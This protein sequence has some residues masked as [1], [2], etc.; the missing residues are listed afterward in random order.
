MNGQ[1]VQEGCCKHVKC[2]KCLISNQ[3]GC[4]Q[5]LE[6]KVV[7]EQRNLRSCTARARSTRS[8]TKPG[9]SNH[10]PITNGFHHQNALLPAAYSAGGRE[11]CPQPPNLIPSTISTT[12]CAGLGIGAGLTNGFHEVSPPPPSTVTRKR[13][14]PIPSNGV[15]KRSRLSVKEVATAQPVLRDAQ[16]NQVRLSASAGK[17]SHSNR[18]PVQTGSSQNRSKWHSPDGQDKTVP[19]SR[20]CLDPPPLTTVEGPK[21][22]LRKTTVLSKTRLTYGLSSD[23]EESHAQFAVTITPTDYCRTSQPELPLKKRHSPNTTTADLEVGPSSPAND[24]V[25]LNQT[26]SLTSGIEENEKQV[27]PQTSKP[28]EN[29]APVP[30]VEGRIKKKR[31]PVTIHDHISILNGKLLISNKNDLKKTLILEVY[32]FV[33]LYLG[34]PPLYQCGI[35]T[36]KFKTKAHIKYHEFCVEGEKPFKCEECGQG[37]IAKSHFEYHIRTHT[38]ERPYTCPK[39]GKGFNQRG[40]VTRHMR[41]HTGEKPFVCTECGRGFANTQAMR[42]HFLIHTGERPFACEYCDKRFTG[43]TNLKKHVITHTGKI[44]EFMDDFVSLI[45]AHSFRRAPFYVYSLW[46]ELWLKMDTRSPFT[47][48]FQ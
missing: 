14:L 7:P 34:D 26:G 25:Q 37:F 41:S 2:R 48:S 40:K 22:H 43:M 18:D 27:L 13:L 15:Q 4:I 36:K 28:Q 12:A 9:A 47:N 3:A 38:G 17:E 23:K 42:S 20:P 19:T 5:C 46:E 39:C 10:P 16:Q 35:C 24:S 29:T 44:K 32:N 6:V 30:K 8:N 1:P 33:K 31:N 45:F 21:S 11:S